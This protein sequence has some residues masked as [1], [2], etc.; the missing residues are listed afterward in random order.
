ME[1]TASRRAHGT[2][3]VIVVLDATLTPEAVRPLC[4]RA[5]RQLQESG[6]GLLVC[7]VGEA[8][9]DCVTVDA[10]ARLQLTACRLGCRLRV[11]R[12]S[13][14][15]RSL[16]AFTGLRGIVPA[17]PASGRRA[18]PEEREQGLGVEEEGQLD[19]PAA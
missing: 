5:R 12:A 16:L 3:A 8:P 9:P 7:D 14:E 19:D 11:R 10:L 2:G 15:L 4:A 18:Y 6:A 17:D 13:G 1:M